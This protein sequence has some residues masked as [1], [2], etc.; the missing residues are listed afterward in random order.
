MGDVA[1]SL[2][3]LRTAD[4]KAETQT[5]TLSMSADAMTKLAESQPELA[6]LFNRLLN[7]ALAEK[8]MTANRM[9][10]HAG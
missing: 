6:A 10:E 5:V 4:V 1:Y 9:T 7:R 2:G 8:V 3:G